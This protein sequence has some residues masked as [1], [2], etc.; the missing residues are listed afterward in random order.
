MHHPFS[1]I[2]VVSGTSV[3]V[4]GIGVRVGGIGVRVGVEVGRGVNVVVGVGVQAAC[5]W[6]MDVWIAC[7]DGA[8][9]VNKI[10]NIHAN[11]MI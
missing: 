9:A 3:R 8:Q 11:A 2:Y 4:G 7:C 5:V 6:A 10:I 1:R